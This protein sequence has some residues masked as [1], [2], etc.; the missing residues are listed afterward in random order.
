MHLIKQ[1]AHF[2][3]YKFTSFDVLRM[4]PKNNLVDIGFSFV[5]FSTNRIKIHGTEKYMHCRWKT[6]ELSGVRST[7]ACI[8]QKN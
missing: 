5:C 8:S 6:L 2:K 3:D 7:Y 4:Q 1:S